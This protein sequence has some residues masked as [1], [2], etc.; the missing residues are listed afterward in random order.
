MCV[1]VDTQ[2]EIKILYEKYAYIAEV[3]TIRVSDGP[4]IVFILKWHVYL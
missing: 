4:S 1:C 3:F 2:I